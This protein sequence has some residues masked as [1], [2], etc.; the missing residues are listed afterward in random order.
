MKALFFKWVIT[1]YIQTLLIT[2]QRV[3]LLHQMQMLGSKGDRPQAP[4]GSGGGGGGQQGGGGGSTSA[5]EPPPPDM[6][7]IPF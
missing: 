6:E 4:S 7:D 1:F 2:L 5:E 3:S